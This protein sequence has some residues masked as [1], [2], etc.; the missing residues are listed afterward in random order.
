MRIIALIG[1]LLLTACGH[2]TQ[3]PI[4]PAQIA[5]SIYIPPGS[6]EVPAT[7]KPGCN[8]FDTSGCPQHHPNCF[9]SPSGWVC[10]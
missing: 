7:G 8:A 1:L 2:E 9:E 3:T 4:A 10:Q 5:P 6:K